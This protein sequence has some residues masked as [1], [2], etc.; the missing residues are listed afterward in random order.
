[1]KQTRHLPTPSAEEKERFF[2]KFS[3]PKHGCWLWHGSCISTGYGQYGLS[4][5][6][7]LAHRIMYLLATGND[8]G[9]LFVLHKCDTPRCVRPDHLW[10]GTDGDNI[11]DA[12]AKGRW[13][14]MP[15]FGGD[16]EDNAQAKLTNKEVLAIRSL[17]DT[18][19]FTQIELG[20]EFG[21]SNSQIHLIVKRKEWVHI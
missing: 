18:R 4:G 10:L 15:G 5:E 12:V 2:S 19:T 13:V 11:R 9:S 6:C 16:G 17:W 14:K 3:A 8:P 7:Y 20:R 1:M 21:V